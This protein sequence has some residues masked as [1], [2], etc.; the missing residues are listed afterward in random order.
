MFQLFLDW[1][2]VSVSVSD[3]VLFIFSAVASLFILNFILDFFRFIM[4]YIS[5]GK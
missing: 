5:G 4:Y 2:N 1:M 3:D